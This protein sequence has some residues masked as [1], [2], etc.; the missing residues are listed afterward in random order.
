VVASDFDE[1]MRNITVKVAARAMVGPIACCNEEW[2]ALNLNFTKK[3]F[4]V[5][6][7]LRFIPWVLRP[8][9]WLILF[10]N[11]AWHSVRR[12][13]AKSKN[14]I[15]PLIEAHRSAAEAET[16]QSNTTP[17]LL[18]WIVVRV[19]RTGVVIATKAAA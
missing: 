15:G 5:S 7:F 14:I 4:A 6:Y 18:Q 2:N 11:P 13:I 3:V 19:F 17:T 8:F 1:I 12:D 9:T 16:T 10:F